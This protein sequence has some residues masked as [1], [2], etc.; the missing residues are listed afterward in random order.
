M[1]CGSM[2]R[3]VASKLFTRVP[4]PRQHVHYLSSNVVIDPSLAGLPVQ[5]GCFVFSPRGLF[6]VFWNSS[7]KQIAN[8]LWFNGKGGGFQA[9]Y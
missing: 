8:W 6:Y 4:I 1:G 9:V 2:M 7:Y 5:A 3:V